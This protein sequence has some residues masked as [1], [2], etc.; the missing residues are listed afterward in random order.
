[1]RLFNKFNLFQSDMST[2]TTTTPQP[3]SKKE[4]KTFT[5][6]CPESFR[7]INRV[8]ASEFRYAALKCVTNQNKLLKKEQLPSGCLMPDGRFRILL[9]QTNTR[10]IREYV[11]EIC[12]LEN[13]Q[14]VQRQGREIKYTKKP[15]VS[16]VRSFIFDGSTPMAE[17]EE[18]EQPVQEDEK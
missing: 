14:V 9:R 17:E 4:K 11:G 10:L 16:F 15:K 3:R 18:E 13:P 2:D 12:E 7:V 8:Q 5:S 6:H 1:M